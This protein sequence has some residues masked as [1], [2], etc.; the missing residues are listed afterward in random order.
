MIEIDISNTTNYVVIKYL[1]I[2]KKPRRKE[3]PNKM[4]LYSLTALLLCFYVLAGVSASS[5]ISAQ[6][7]VSSA[8]YLFSDNATT[9]I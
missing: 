1:F 7:C 8:R 3:T 5:L 4:A 9:M 2:M 6:K